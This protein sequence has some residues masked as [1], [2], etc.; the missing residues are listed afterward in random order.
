[1]STLLVE[2]LIRADN[3]YFKGYIAN[4]YNQNRVKFYLN[5]IYN[6]SEGVDVPN[7]EYIETSFKLIFYLIKKYITTL[8]KNNN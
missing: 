3:E 1:M 6:I 4:F 7:G 5:Y 2:G 8:I